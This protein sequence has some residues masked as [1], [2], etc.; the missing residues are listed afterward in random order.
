MLLLRTLP[1][2]IGAAEALIVCIE[3][4]LVPSLP[5]V[6]SLTLISFQPAPPRALPGNTSLRDS[7]VD[8]STSTILGGGCHLAKAAEEYHLGTL[9]ASFEM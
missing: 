2:I 3:K 6:A 1:P 8:A 5:Y 7:D 4:N 9:R